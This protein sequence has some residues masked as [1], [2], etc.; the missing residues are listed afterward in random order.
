MTHFAPT[1]QHAPL[2]SLL[3]FQKENTYHKIKEI[4]ISFSITIPQCINHNVLHLHHENNIEVQP[5][6]PTLDYYQ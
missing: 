6:R 1:K 2:L 4:K 5:E 3:S